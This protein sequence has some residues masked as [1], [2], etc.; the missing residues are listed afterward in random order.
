M[1]I[2][3]CASEYDCEWDN[4]CY[5]PHGNWVSCVIRRAWEWKWVRQCVREWVRVSH[6]YPHS[7]G[8]HMRSFSWRLLFVFHLSNH[9]WVILETYSD[10]HL[11]W[12]WWS[13][14]VTLAWQANTV[15]HAKD[16]MLSSLLYVQ[17]YV[18]V[19]FIHLVLLYSAFSLQY[20]G[21]KHFQTM[22]RIINILIQSQ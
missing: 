4:L 12:W 6:V 19:L 9:I 8:A 1:Q 2:K 17:R 16:F 14:G 21:S 7:K 18:Y 10:R 20:R 15:Y 13:L 11:G 5:Q 3:R 22:T